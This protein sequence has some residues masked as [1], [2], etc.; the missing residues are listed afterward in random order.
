MYRTGIDY[1]LAHETWERPVPRERVGF[2]PERI[3]PHPR[4]EAVG[5]FG[6]GTGSRCEP[7]EARRSQLCP[8]YFWY[9]ERRWRPRNVAV[10]YRSRESEASGEMA[11][12][13]WRSKVPSTNAAGR[14]RRV[15]GRFM[16]RPVHRRT[17]KAKPCDERR[18]P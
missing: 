13:T 15:L 2:C 18:G 6:R 14:L 16:M 3:V 17:R 5:H 4:S 12:K 8:A 10:A 7:D 11:R 1:L 9:V